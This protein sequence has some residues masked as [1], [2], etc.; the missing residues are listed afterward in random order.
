MKLQKKIRNEERLGNIL[1]DIEK[2]GECQH[3]LKYVL[4]K[5][6]QIGRYKVKQQQQQKSRDIRS[7]KEDST[8]AEN[9]KRRR[10]RKK[11]DI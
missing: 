9:I 3:L 11:K 8:P 4:K 10:R 6:R 7:N 5:S 1:I 2:S